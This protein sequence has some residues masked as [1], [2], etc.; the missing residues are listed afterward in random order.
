[1]WKWFSVLGG[2]FNRCFRKY[3]TRST[4][5]HSSGHCWTSDTHPSLHHCVLSPCFLPPSC[6]F[7]PLSCTV[8]PLALQPCQRRCRRH[9][10]P[11]CCLSLAVIPWGEHSQFSCSQPSR[12]NLSRKEHSEG[13]NNLLR[14]ME[15]EGWKDVEMEGWR[16]RAWGG[17]VVLYQAWLNLGIDLMNN[18]APVSMW[19]Y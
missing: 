7:P 2:D 10:C 13:G 9:W 6:A 16:G 3:G 8:L 11:P 15:E 14:N 18:R 5:S 19:Q 1:M 4:N 17:Q 12:L